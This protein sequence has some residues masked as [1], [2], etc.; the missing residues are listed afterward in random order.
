MAMNSKFRY[1]KVFFVFSFVC[2]FLPFLTWL[3]VVSIFDENFWLNIGLVLF[4][5]SLVSEIWS[6]FFKELLLSSPFLINETTTFFRNINKLNLKYNRIEGLSDQYGG[7]NNGFLLRE[8]GSSSY[9]F[10]FILSIINLFLWPLGLMI[11]FFFVKDY[12]RGY[13]EIK[14]K[15]SNSPI[16]VLIDYLSE[17]NNVTKKQIFSILQLYVHIVSL[18][19]IDN[20]NIVKNSTKFQFDKFLSESENLEISERDFKGILDSFNPK[21]KELFLSCFSGDK[22]QFENGYL[23]NQ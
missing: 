5:V 15:R 7:T 18:K 16:W 6:L 17:N 3:F 22:L 12:F 21:V 20:Y 8:L 1:F 2:Y 4:I 9:V 10:S 19:H 13:A 14:F 23:E 11:I